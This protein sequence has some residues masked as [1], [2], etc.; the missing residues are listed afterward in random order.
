METTLTHWINGE[1]V[2]VSAALQGEVG[3]VEKSQVIRIRL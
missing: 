2:P 3:S 1:S